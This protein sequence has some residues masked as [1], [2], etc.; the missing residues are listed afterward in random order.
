MDKDLTKRKGM[1]VGET[2]NG[3]VHSRGIFNLDEMP[4]VLL[5]EAWHRYHPCTMTKNHRN[6]L[7]TKEK[8]PNRTAHSRFGK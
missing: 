4:M 1:T 6:R 8:S 7:S 5:D 3:A 2:R